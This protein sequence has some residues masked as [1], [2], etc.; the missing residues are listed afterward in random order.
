MNMEQ[1]RNDNSGRNETIFWMILG[2][3]LVV[4]VF[5]YGFSLVLLSPIFA[6]YSIL[7]ILLFIRTRNM[8]Y[9]IKSLMFFFLL[10]FVILLFF[11]GN[12]ILTLFM[13]GISLI[14]LVWLIILIA[15]RDYKWRTSQMLE[16]AAMPV[17]EIK[18]G[19]TMRPMPAGKADFEW[20]EL[21]R[22]SYFIRRNLISVPYYEKDKV[23]FS[24]NRSRIKLISFSSNYIQDSWVAFE[25]SGQVSVHISKEDYKMYKDNYAFDQLCNSLGNLYV[26]FFKLFRQNKE[27]EII[28]RIDIIRV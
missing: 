1:K 10:L 9:M 25:R 18:N 24:L 14:F 23:I 16:L 19:Y 11:T 22:Y 6:V 2:P 27:A 4:L 21:L 13:G 15:I 8:G 3:L 17:D 5:L 28:R 26:D 20:N 7:S 12:K